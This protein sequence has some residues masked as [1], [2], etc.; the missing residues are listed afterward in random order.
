MGEIETLEDLWATRR[1]SESPPHPPKW[2]YP[3]WTAAVSPGS[4]VV[5]AS[6]T[7]TVILSS[8]LP[9]R[10][11]PVPL[12]SL[13]VSENLVLGLFV[14]FCF[15]SHGLRPL[16]WWGEKKRSKETVGWTK[17]IRPVRQPP[18]GIESNNGTSRAASV[19]VE[20]QLLLSWSISSLK[21]F[22]RVDNWSPLH[23]IWFLLSFCSFF[24]FLNVNFIFGGNTGFEIHPLIIFYFYCFIYWEYPPDNSIIPSPSSCV[25]LGVHG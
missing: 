5:A 23:R 22:T 10:A 18:A 1:T 11:S 20:H 25:Q 7:L 15:Y 14:F 2:L 13:T 8:L 12:E 3:I 6:T 4:F 24:R 19:S 16:I 9:G 17:V 21:T